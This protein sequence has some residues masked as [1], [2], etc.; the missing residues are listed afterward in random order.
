MAR[1]WRLYFIFPVLVLASAGIGGG[2]FRGI[3][4]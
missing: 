4:S 1:A 3:F 2:W